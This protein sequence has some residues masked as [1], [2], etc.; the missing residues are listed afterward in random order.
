MRR[1]LKPLRDKRKKSQVL[2][3]INR[4]IAVI[5]LISGF[6]LLSVVLSSSLISQTAAGIS[7]SFQNQA[8][9]MVIN[10]HFHMGGS[11]LGLVLKRLRAS[12]KWPVKLNGTSPN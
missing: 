1:Y 7:S 11:A 2:Q 5:A 12:S 3:L 6:G 9:S 8:K 10:I 4:I